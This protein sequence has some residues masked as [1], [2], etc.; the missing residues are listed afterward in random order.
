MQKKINKP[1]FIIKKED[2]EKI[3]ASYDIKEEEKKAA[4]AY[5]K[6]I[7]IPK[8]V[9][10]V[11]YSNCFTTKT[12]G[13]HEYI[14][15]CDFENICSC[16]LKEEKQVVIDLTGEVK[17]PVG[18]IDPLLEEVTK[19][20]TSNMASLVSLIEDEEYEKFSKLIEISSS[21]IYQAI[22]LLEQII[23][24][25]QER[26]KEEENKQKKKDA[27]EKLLIYLKEYKEY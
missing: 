22:L 9:C 7:T 10:P 6:A 11:S 23:K 2:L 8:Y 17:T 21:T 3:K 24:E 5:K 13:G 25:K 14:C 1:S 16:D 19:N 4:E 26:K 12:E 20:I 18:L 15:S 27:A